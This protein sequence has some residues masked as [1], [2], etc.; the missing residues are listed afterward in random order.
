MFAGILPLPDPMVWPVIAYVIFAPGQFSMPI[1][2]SAVVLGHT[3]LP[4]VHTT[5]SLLGQLMLGT[6]VSTTVMMKLHILV[7]P[8]LSV[9]VNTMVDTP[10]AKVDP[11]AMPLV[12]TTVTGLLQSVAIGV[13]YT[14]LDAQRSTSTLTVIFAGQLL[15]TGA[16]TSLLTTI[17]AL[18]LPVAPQPS[19]TVHVTVWLPPHKLGRMPV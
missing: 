2:L 8:H 10:N 16:V 18:L 13:L 5:T 12:R 15:N 7:F 1:G 11:D 4:F 9:A 19:V 6:S 14:T 3:Q 17:I